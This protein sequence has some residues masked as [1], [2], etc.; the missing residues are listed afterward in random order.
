MIMTHWWC[1]GSGARGGGAAVCSI[2]ELRLIWS[3]DHS[4]NEHVDTLVLT[5]TDILLSQRKN[6][7]V[8]GK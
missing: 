1:G 6:L 3:C 5:K 8:K 2:A 7:Q 4:F